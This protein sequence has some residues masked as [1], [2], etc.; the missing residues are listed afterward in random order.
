MK[1][2]YLSSLIG[3]A[4]QVY[5]GGPDSN[6]GV[7]LNVNSDYLTLQKEDGEIIY[8]KTEHIKSI[9]ENS[10]IRFNSV[11]KVYDANNLFKANTF[12]ELA[13]NF[14]DQTVRI[15]GKGPE[16]KHGI[17]LDVRADFLVLS[18]EADGLIFYK[19]HYVTSLSHA[20]PVATIEAEEVVNVKDGSSAISE[21]ETVEELNDFTEMYSQIA[22]NTTNDILSNLKYSLVKINRKGPES[23]E[24]MLVEANED[25]LV[26][27]VNNEVFRISAFHV[28]NFSVNPTKT[29]D[30]ESEQTTEQSTT[31]ETTNEPTAEEQTTSV[32]ERLSA[33]QLAT[34]NRTNV[35]RRRRNKSKKQAKEQ[36]TTIQSEPANTIKEEIQ[37]IEQATPSLTE[38]EKVRKQKPKRR[39]LQEK[40]VRV[41]GSEKPPIRFTNKRGK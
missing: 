37:I 33:G 28:E 27:V 14:K 16:S 21:E 22:A 13:V 38:E 17:L 20:L 1:D 2:E 31:E 30:Q 18:T 29:E 23:I 19:E 34:S 6:I 11:L 24:G 26:L 10:Q 39:I 32:V 3:R 12:N 4:V 7:L 5:K 15:N 9:R 40:N 8:Y 36:A 25:H 35:N 41:R